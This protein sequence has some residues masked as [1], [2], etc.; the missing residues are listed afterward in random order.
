MDTFTRSDLKLLLDPR[1]G[2][3]VSAFLPTHR[4]GSEQDPTRYKNL[5]RQAEDRLTAHG[6]R[7][8]EAGDLLE[9]ARELLADESFWRAQSDGLALFLAPGFQRRYRLPVAFPERVVVGD[10]FHV[11]PLLPL[12]NAGGRFYVLALSQK[13]VRLLQGTAH[14][15]QDL[16]LAGVP[17]G[18]AE[19][20]RFH[21]TDEPLLFHTRPNGRHGGWSA[22]FHGHGV[23]IDDHKDDLLAYFRAVDRGLHEI[24][25]TERAPL[26]LA[27]VEYLWPIYREANRYPH[28]LE[29]GIAGNPDGLSAEE[30]CRRALALVRPHWRRAQAEAAALYAQL[31]GT[32]RASA[33]LPEVVQAAREGRVEILFVESGRRVWGRAETGAAHERE[34]PGDEDLLNR[35]TADT[36][37]HGGTV[38]ASA[39]E[40]MP[41]G[42]AAAL[43]WLPVRR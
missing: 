21:D 42:P 22:I 18:L 36:L 32:G 29:G 8:P 3:C 41:G 33:D 35:A 40:E 11:E 4:G 10:S 16:D 19:A 5:L 30:L 9:P 24:L 34:E 38:Y 13:H 26:V 1:R 2:P 20:L 27:S 12:L 31:L 37:R 7:G 15:V 39:A 23:G 14:G 17:Q 43:F 25:R 6:V 28:L